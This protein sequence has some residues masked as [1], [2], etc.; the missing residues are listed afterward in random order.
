MSTQAEL[1]SHLDELEK[2]KKQLEDAIEMASQRFKWGLWGIAIGVIL[3]PLYWLG[4]P[5]LLISGATV[6]YYSIKRS[7]SQDKLGDV[8]TEI[9]RLEISMA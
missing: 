5:V 6:L 3:I 8:E 4:I 1:K 9:H 2:Q 7:S